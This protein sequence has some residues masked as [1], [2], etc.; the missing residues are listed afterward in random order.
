M[1]FHRIPLIYLCLLSLA[2]CNPS[3]SGSVEGVVKVDGEPMGGFFVHFEPDSSGGNPLGSAREGG[4]YRLY[5]G[6]GSEEI[7]VGSYRVFVEPTDM[8]EG[9]DRPKVKI[10]P[11]FLNVESTP[12]VVDVKPGKNQFDINL[13]TRK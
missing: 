8:V 6:R 2:G 9:I 5:L 13:T 1:S 7:P 10:S 3:T 11:E 4:V 12:L